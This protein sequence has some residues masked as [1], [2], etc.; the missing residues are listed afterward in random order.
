MKVTGYYCYIITIARNVIISGRAGCYAVVFFDLLLATERT[1]IV[2]FVSDGYQRA[3][4]YNRTETRSTS[5]DTN[6]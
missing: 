6:G 5:L 4:N 1:V 3:E 2:I